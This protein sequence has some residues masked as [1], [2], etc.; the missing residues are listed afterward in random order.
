M[1]RFHVLIKNGTL[2]DGTGTER[3]R[4][5]LGI[6][7]DR[8]AAVGAL[9]GSEADLV[10]DAAGHVVAPGFVDVHN[11]SDGWL[12]KLGHLAPKTAQGFTT[13]VLM[14][15]GISYAPVSPETAPH[16]VFYLRSLNGLEQRDYRGWETIDD[17]LALL[18]RRSAQNSIAQIP[19]A[20]LRSMAV[21]WGRAPADD[22]QRLR[23]RH[24]VAQAMERGAA[25][26]STGLDYISQ[27]FA[28]TE[29]LIDVCRA[30]SPWRGLYVTH[31]RYKQGLLEA[32]REAVDIARGADVPLHVS[33][34]KAFDPE[35]VDSLL[36]FI[37]RH[38]VNEVDFSFDVYPYLPGSTM[39]NSL[40]PY[41]VWE[42]GPLGVPAKLADATIRRR[43]AVQIAAY[44][45]TIDRIRIAWVGAPGH[46]EWIGRTL[47]EYVDA[48]R[49]PPEDAL[50]DLLIDAN[51]AVLCVFHMGDDR[52][53]EP[54]LAHPNFM[55]GSDAIY[56]ED[57]AIHP[58]CYGSAPRLLG[59]L[60][61]DRN[62]FS[63]ES[64]V[65]RASGYPAERFGLI[66]RGVLREGAFADVVV[67]DP[68]TVNDQA[69]YENPHAPP[70]GVPHVLVNGIPVIRDGG[71]VDGLGPEWPGRSLAYR[72]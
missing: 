39:L 44:R 12:L 63:L 33:H 41:E 67:F 56:F 37:D 48:A 60:V 50:C 42:D 38:A 32:M 25:G 55:L 14:S 22:A 29:E 59:P 34:L 6:A 9:S 43:F 20:N 40:L 26:I 52:L 66:D 51:L 2:I 21:G 10:I 64:A 18:D 46:D 53:V 70:I 24:E 28:T 8:V 57:G 16:W 5:D 4:A 58:R 35:T 27:C 19:Y 54:F 36:E 69:T 49:K 23:M 3:R 15:D 7:G 71:P 11:H 72:R 31:I 17:Y 45:T 62:L 30:M 1:T 47:Q 61:R 68:E 65:R 13:E